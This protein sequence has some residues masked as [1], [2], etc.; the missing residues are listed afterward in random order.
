MNDR[1]AMPL[2]PALAL[3]QATT[4]K[5]LEQEWGPGTSPGND[6][7]DGWRTVAWTQTWFGQA[8][9]KA[10]YTFDPEGCLKR[11]DLSAAESGPLSRAMRRDLGEPDQQGPSPQFLN[12]MSYQSWQR[13]GIG[14]NLEDYAPGCTVGILPQQ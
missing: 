7:R 2:D 11:I 8:G 9:V 14:F 1:T 6:G 5:A 4:L 3:T 13:E 12:S 10:V